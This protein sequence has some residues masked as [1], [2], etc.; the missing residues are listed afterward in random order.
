MARLIAASTLSLGMLTARAFWNARRSA[1]LCSGFGPPALTAIVIS[2][3]M[4]ANALDILSQ[5]ANIVAL[6]V[7]KMRPIVDSAPACG[8]CMDERAGAAREA[9]LQRGPTPR[10]C[11]VA[12]A[13]S[14]RGL[15]GASP[16]LREQPGEHVRAP[17][18]ASRPAEELAEHLEVVAAGDQRRLDGAVLAHLRRGRRW[19]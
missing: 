2:L 16:A 9:A 15:S 1:G 5:R 14:T 7:S 17:S 8:T 13:P 18:S 4:R 6:R 3:P 10:L 12:R 11:R 19:R